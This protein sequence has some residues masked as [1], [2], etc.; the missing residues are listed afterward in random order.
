M[1]S[2]GGRPDGSADEA[3]AVVTADGTLVGWTRGAQRLLGHR[4]ADVVGRPGGPLV[5]SADRARVS[6]IAAACRT[7]TGWRGT[8]TLRDRAG[9]EIPTD[10][11]VS[12]A[13]RMADLG[14]CFLVTGHERH[15]DQAIGQSVLDGFL[16]RAPIGM[17]VMSPELRY[18]WL[19][20]VLERFGGVPREQRIGRRLSE[21]MPGL[22]AE[23]LENLMEKVLLTGVPVMDHEY[24]GWSWADPH[25]EHAYSTS[26]FPLTGTD[27]AV[28]GVCYMVSDVTDRWAAQQRLVFMN[29]AGAR[30]GRSL[31]VLRTAQELA[32]VVVPRFADL[33]VVDLL[34]SALSTDEPAALHSDGMPGMFRAGLQSVRPGAP[35]ALARVGEPV[36][37]V[38][39]PHDRTYL[40]DGEGV[41]MP[42]LDPGSPEWAVKD[43]QRAARMREYAL[44]SLISVP[45]RARDT[46][47]GLATFLRSENLA[48]FAPDDLLLAQELAARAAV[49]LDNARRY[50]RERNTALTLQRN[51]L[52]QA[53]AGV[54]GLET[55]YVY[56]PAEA[57]DGVGGDWFDVLPLSSARVG[58]VVGDVVGHGITAAATMGRLRTAVHTLADMDLPPA[59]L[60]AH[61][62][63]LVIRLTE[64]EPPDGVTGNAVLGATCLYAVYDP[65]T[66]Q[67]E[68]ARAGHPPPA[69]VAPD[70][71]VGFP[72]LPVGPPLGLGGMPFESGT[73]ELAEGST[74]GLYTD[75]LIEGI[76]RDVDLG[77]RRL[78]E[79]LARTG[80]PL[81]DLCAEA[82]RRLVPGP[83]PDDVALLLAR[84]R[85]LKPT[86][87]I[88]WE[89]PF[90]PSAVADSR[91]EVARQLDAWGLSELTM[92]TE[93]IVSELL[94]NAIRYATGPL[95]LRLLR[96]AFLTCEVSDT[97][98][99]S[100][101][102]RHARALD[103][104]GR[105]LFLVAQL[106]RRWGT[107]HTP[108]GKTIW[109]EQDLP[110]AARG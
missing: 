32:D 42:V 43:P 44:H 101:R 97:S 84:P 36:E 103:E 53:L 48:S 106:T 2:A 18:V 60:L 54:T 102:M 108:E 11:S 87:V 83:Q 86:Q 110:P 58:L 107:R 16:T 17:A 21:F 40:L 33:A 63:D 104:N 89:I 50:T 12:A 15:P 105:G 61:L 5:A 82:V 62:D 90:D 81:D 71:T 29:D 28:T 99:T 27:G 73:L 64:E 38:P 52:P 109:A 23:K 7:G 56:L 77:M 22:Q 41:L 39:P 98:S 6:R 47:L 67:C 49:G 26:F 24:R 93:L 19:N 78:A 95:R 74:I 46:V 72:D 79:V 88:S 55:A 14:D 35:E 68:L 69:V 34:D 70:G 92:S 1:A 65:V 100:P 51:L 30:L 10:V 66:R 8:V 80:L 75:G 20:D 91:I 45:L 85:P 9:R 31:D 57:K 13:F 76:G 4:A 59:E 3:T 37:F 94:A 25:H 96:H